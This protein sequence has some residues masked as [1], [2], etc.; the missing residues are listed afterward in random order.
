VLT[1]PPLTIRNKGF[2]QPHRNHLP[3]RHRQKLA[4]PKLTLEPPV[5]LPVPFPVSALITLA[6]SASAAIHGQHHS[7][8]QPPANHRDPSPPPTPP[9]DPLQ[10]HISHL[11]HRRQRRLHTRHYHALAPARRKKKLERDMCMQ[12]VASGM[13]GLLSSQGGVSF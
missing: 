11:P 3:R 1:Q 8:A 2:I 9:T 10:P 5:F 12:R 13:G 4:P 7:S 6:P